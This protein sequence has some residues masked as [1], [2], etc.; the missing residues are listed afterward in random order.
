MARK[1]AIF[2]TLLIFPALLM[3]G[4]FLKMQGYEI[5]YYCLTCTD[6]YM[7]YSYD[8][9]IKT[10]MKL[11]EVDCKETPPFLVLLVT[12]TQDQKEARDAIRKT[13]GK[14]RL[15]HGK[16]VV[17]YFL[18]GSK[19]NE[20]AKEKVN[21]AKESVMYNDIIQR[22]FI[23]TYYNLTI[24]TLTGIDWIS[25]YCPQAS[26]IMKTDSDMFVNIFYL[27]ELLLRK[28]QTSNFFTGILKPDDGPIR[29][30]FSKWY[31]SKKEYT[32]EKYPPF[33]S[34]TGYVFSMD[35]AQKIYIIS[36]I[37]PFFKLED[38]YVGMCLE[39]LKI[40]LQELHSEPTFFATKP[41]F[42]VCT[43]QRLVTSHEVTPEEMLTYWEALQRSEVLC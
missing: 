26:Y 42:S 10:F 16:R 36:S 9:S 27:V 6:N 38:V 12:T 19:E 24:K 34:G 11:P 33:C 28:N 17:S 30:R 7:V 15:I 37:M 1:R 29:M 25:N 5:W 13:W 22:N 32:K 4:L 31:I 20:S 14:E 18:L 8:Y 21:L 2:I 41:P 3:L 43:Y 40:R 35:V 39:Q 23:D